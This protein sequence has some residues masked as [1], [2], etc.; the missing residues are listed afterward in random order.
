MLNNSIKIHN[1]RMEE[2]MN[3]KELDKYE[4]QMDKILK[5]NQCNKYTRCID[6]CPLK[7]G[8][9]LLNLSRIADC[10]VIGL[11]AI[12]NQWRHNDDEHSKNNSR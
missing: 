3:R 6:G 2:K 8:K 11:R 1:K 10:S 12:I 5:K 4:K 7:A 9:L